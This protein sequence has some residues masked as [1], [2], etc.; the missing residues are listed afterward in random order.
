MSK[1][2]AVYWNGFARNLFIRA[3]STKGNAERFVRSSDL[4]QYYAFIDRLMG[5]WDDN[6]SFYDNID[7]Y[8]RNPIGNI[9]FRKG[10]ESKFK[11][12]EYSVDDFSAMPLNPY[13]CTH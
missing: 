6:A 2:F 13:D 4:R 10:F 8:A 5:C 3:F 9:P 12:I 7:L 1:I 11:I